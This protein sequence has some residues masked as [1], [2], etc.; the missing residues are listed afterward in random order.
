MV[1]LSK[2]E[3]FLDLPSNHVNKDGGKREKR[4]KEGLCPIMQHAHYSSYQS[5]AP[6]SLAQIIFP[7][8]C[9]LECKKG[10]ES[11]FWII[12]AVFVKGAKMYTIHTNLQIA[13][14]KYLVAHPTV[15]TSFRPLY[16]AETRIRLEFLHLTFMYTITWHSSL[17]YHNVNPK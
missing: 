15:L 14:G 1:K 7:V 13:T 2:I 12:F 10:C 5:P 17:Y 16:A 9:T 6:S 11:S 8:S 3:T 4:Q